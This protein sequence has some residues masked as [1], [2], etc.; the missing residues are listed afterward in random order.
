MRLHTL[1][2]YFYCFQTLA[3]TSPNVVR[4]V[5][6]DGQWDATIHYKAD[7]PGGFLYLQNNALHYTFYDTKAVA[8]LHAAKENT[9]NTRTA[10][11]L[12]A[13]GV[14]V[15]FE[16]ANQH[17]Q[18]IVSQEVSE[19]RNYY[20]GN[21]PTHW[22]SNVPAFGEI[23]YKNL[24]PNI[25]LRLYT[26]GNSLKY[27]FLVAAGADPSLIRIRY[28]GANGIAIE[29]GN[30]LIS[31][32]V[33]TI[34]ELQP[35]SFQTTGTKSN[36]VASNFRITD[37]I[38]SFDFP[39]GLS[40]TLPLVIDPVL[41]FSS[42]SGSYADNWGHTATYDDEGNLLSGG[43]VFDIQAFP[44][45]QGAFQTQFGGIWDVAILKFAG[46]GD[47]L[48]YA[49]YIGGA[50][51]EVPHSIVCTT[52]GELIVFGTTSSTNFP[53]SLTAYDRSFNGG[54]NVTAVS[55]M[56][57]TNGSD[58]Y[59][60]K[61]SKDGTKLIGSTYVGGSDNDGI[62]FNRSNLLI[63][64]Y[65]DEYRGEVVLDANDNIYVASSTV[66]TNFPMQN[67]DR[68]VRAGSA[69]AVVFRLNPDLSKLEWSTFLGGNGFDVAYGIRA[70]KTGVYVCGN[71]NSTD[72]QA[73][74]NA[75]KRTIGG[76]E[77][78]FAVRYVND[79]L[80]ALTYLGTPEPDAAQMIDLDK[81]ENVYVVGITAGVYPVAN[82]AYQNSRSGQ[83]IQ[84]MDNNLSKSLFSTV[85]GSGRGTPDIVPTAF[86]IN[87]CGNIYLAGWGGS[88]NASLSAP[89]AA[90]SST[91]GLP[92]TPD[93]YRTSTD[94][95]NFY[96]MIL[97]TGAK[98]L[99]Y[100]TFF[101]STNTEAGDHVD[102]GTCR[103]D[104]KGFI[105]HAACA[106]NRDGSPANFTT[107]NGS[108]S[109]TN[110]AEN[111]NNAAFKFDIDTLQVSFDAFK[112]A[113]KNVLTGCA[114]L[115]L[116]FVNTSVGGKTYD[117]DLGG[118]AKST[119]PTETSY[120]FDK[121]GEYTIKL[122]G[123]NPLSCN[124]EKSAQKI[125]K[126]TPTEFNVVSPPRI[127]TGGSVQLSASGATTY[128]W[129]PAE[130]LNRTDIANPVANP[131]S[132][133]TYTVEMT[134]AAG[135][136]ST[137]TVNVE[138]DT[139][140]K[141]DFTFEKTF[142]CGQPVSLQLINK[143]SNADRIVWDL[144]NGDTLRTPN[145]PPYIYKQP[146][147]YQITVKAYRGTCELSTSKPVEIE[148]PYVV[149]NVI[150]PNGDGKND[151]FV[152]SQ[153]GVRVEIYNRWG[154]LM[155][156]SD[157]YPSDWGK[158]VSNGTYYYLLTTPSGSKCKGWLE[159][160]E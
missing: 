31:T 137:R 84:A 35:Y 152:I 85:V 145:P 103:F 48:V 109:R 53:T 2:F 18:I 32:S 95:N 125:I 88:I 27:E 96:I 7:L 133:T 47:K 153:K 29:K 122:K 21:D 4:F 123:I 68:N 114:P 149:S 119:A 124:R 99:L 55:G 121:G 69:D 94:G 71:T 146:G 39:N 156:Q 127:C 58:I 143:T 141:P 80:A 3:E 5:R 129:S 41:I 112:G 116:R 28:K 111:C 66:S 34:K 50:R 22:A 65:G 54:R 159:V 90:Q 40:P 120:T 126:V 36:E 102:G 117:W 44:V 113:E 157:N 60:I 11:S 100:A 138:V 110:N 76:S 57:Y 154:K 59:L 61:L 78:G 104:K 142:E 151:T 135:C 14:S 72:L 160:M 91:R 148:P 101:G 15:T 106:C 108:W 97:E 86:L 118:L 9:A 13:H 131:K 70:G 20:V 105:Y 128:K 134:N 45:T 63:R 92:V 155:Y 74:T 144:G 89:Y 10:S 115:T 56:D 16:G 26:Y 150:T 6:N 132:S 107:T 77:E 43:S 52:K 17:P 82:A 83:F 33:S 25:D 30:L 1:L 67:P 62:N 140:F 75:L 37:G 38:V 158:N 42:F 24:Y 73:S 12:S 79:R 130:G 19:K 98:S 64:N 139:S 87:E 49:T 93:A 136:V 147:T 8:G 81:D 23:T 46:K 51:T